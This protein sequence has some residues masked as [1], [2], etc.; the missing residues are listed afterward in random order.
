MTGRTKGRGPFAMRFVYTS[1]LEKLA[2]DKLSSRYGVFDQFRQFEMKRM[3]PGF[4]KIAM[5]IGR[6]YDACGITE[7]WIF[8]NIHVF[9]SSPKEEGT[10]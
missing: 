3:V 5:Y 9:R 10:L 7:L 8:P 2:Y 4:P 1:V 6:L